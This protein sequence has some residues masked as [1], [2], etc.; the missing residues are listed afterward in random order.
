MA[1]QLQ[2]SLFEPAGPRHHSDF[3]RHR[4]LA[5]VAKARRA[6]ERSRELAKTR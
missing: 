3:E 6:L 1:R 5:G 4:V 2:L